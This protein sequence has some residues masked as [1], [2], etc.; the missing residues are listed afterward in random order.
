MIITNVERKDKNG[1]R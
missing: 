1:K